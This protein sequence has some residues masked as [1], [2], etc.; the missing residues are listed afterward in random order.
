MQTAIVWLACALGRR[1]SRR[2]NGG[3]G[4]GSS[5]CTRAW[6]C[7]LHAA[8]EL[9]LP[10]SCSCRSR[11]QSSVL[12]EGSLLT[13]GALA[14]FLSCTPLLCSLVGVDRACTA[15]TGTLLTT[16]A[17]DHHHSRRRPALG[18]TSGGLLLSQMLLLRLR[19]KSLAK[20]MLT[21]YHKLCSTGGRASQ[22]RRR[23]HFWAAWL[24]GRVMR[25]LVPLPLLACRQASL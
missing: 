20:R 24:H 23:S 5:P 14:E 12:E 25:C 18:A 4:G 2:A 13:D 16:L 15:A 22:Q 11:R 19:L 8:L 7:T 6:D 9:C 3:G 17:G 21:C 1:G 10:W